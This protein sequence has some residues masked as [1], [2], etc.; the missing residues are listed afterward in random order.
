MTF[1][2]IMLSVVV[3]LLAV[4]VTGLLRSHAEILR[5]LH[6]LGAG[7]DTDEA[8]EAARAERDHAPDDALPRPTRGRTHA[9]S[10]PRGR[11]VWDITGTTLAGDAVALGLTGVPH[12]TTL[13]FLSSGCTTCA[14]FWEA[15][16][17]PGTL[18]LPPGARLVVVT[19]EARSESPAE[20]AELAPSGVT[21]VM[22]DAAWSDYQVAGSPYV[23]HVDGPTGRILG[24]GTG[25]DWPQVS[26]LLAQATG[27]LAYAGHTG[28]RRSK[29]AS[30]AE[31]ERRMD[32][33]LIAAGI[34]PGD[35][36]LYLPQ[37]GDTGAART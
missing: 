6:E 26:R 37:L 2:V 21:L 8:G 18:S 16:A 28:R 17:S 27:D 4:L 10:Q 25:L 34:L 7:A 24:E 13:M 33:E 36:R 1:V 11:A 31:R 20:L 19:R 15:L 23:V 30:D 9:R 35:E 29:A 3:A 14:A 32:D 22:S 5:R 12:D